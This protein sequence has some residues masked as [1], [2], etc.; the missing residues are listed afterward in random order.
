MSNIIIMSNINNKPLQIVSSK[1]LYLFSK[2]KVRRWELG[3]FGDVING[4]LVDEC[5]LPF[6]AK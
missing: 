5:C 2:D 1:L 3:I 6:R 4:C